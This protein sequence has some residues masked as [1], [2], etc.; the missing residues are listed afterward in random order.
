MNARNTVCPSYAEQ[1]AI[2]RESIKSS[3]KIGSSIVYGRGWSQETSK[4][5]FVKVDVE[6]V[7]QKSCGG[8]A[9]AKPMIH[10][11]FPDEPLTVASK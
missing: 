7:V 8:R 4:V 1:R 5:G 11:G 9:N 6:V 2:R 3:K 10:S